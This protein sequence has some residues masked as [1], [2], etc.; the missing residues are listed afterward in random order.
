MQFSRRDVPR[1]L[2]E[3]AFDRAFRKRVVQ[4]NDK[5]FRHARYVP[6]HLDVCSFLAVNDKPVPFENCDHVFP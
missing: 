5:G 1:R 4:G 6:P 2:I 3:N